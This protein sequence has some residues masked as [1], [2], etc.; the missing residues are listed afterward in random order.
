MYHIFCIHSSV[1]GHLGSFW[2][3]A[4]INK[5]AMN[6]VE[7]VSLLYIGASFGYMLRSGISGSSGKTMS[8]YLKNHQTDFKSGYTTLQYPSPPI[9][10]QMKTCSSF[11]TSFP[12]SAVT[13]VFYLSHSDWYEIESQGCFDLHFPDDYGCWTFFQALLSPSVFLSWEFFV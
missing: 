13:W 10:P 9:S 8:N 2:L 3:L 5:D 6:I 1:E 4:T 11:S 12:A 7:C